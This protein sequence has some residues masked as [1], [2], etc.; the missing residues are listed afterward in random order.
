MAK[1]TQKR[2]HID[3]FLEELE[4][5]EG[6]DY[7]VEG[8]VDRVG[9]IDRRLKRGMETVLAEFGLS[10]PDWRVLTTLRNSGSKTP[11]VLA[12]YHD[13]SSGAM[14]S[15]LDSLEQEGLI[16]RVPDP[17]DRRSVVVEI[18][19]KGRNAWA[20]A[21]SIQARREAFFASALTKPEQQRLNALLRKLLLALEEA[22]E[23][24][25]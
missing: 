2:D 20:E 12:R 22:Q 9:A 3:R 13:I 5:V 19:D 15:R 17:D 11:G 1:A 4:P 25:R 7:D 24:A 14:T 10:R 16:R 6:L 21:A 8:I 23:G 18:T